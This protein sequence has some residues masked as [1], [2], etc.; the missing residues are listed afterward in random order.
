VTEA[1]E[2]S[3][4]GPSRAEA[5]E[6]S[7]LV[8]VRAVASAPKARTA[9][10]AGPAS[11]GPRAR[12]SVWRPAPLPRW[13]RPRVPARARGGAVAVIPIPRSVRIFI[14]STPSTMAEIDATQLAML[15]D[16][17]DFGHVRRREH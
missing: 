9:V 8:P 3:E 5:A 16:G 6:G 4:Q 12:A 1:D 2:R 17:I 11:D 14:G 15:L 13:H 10:V 7:R